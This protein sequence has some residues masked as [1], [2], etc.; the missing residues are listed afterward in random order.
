MNTVNS[1]Y[2]KALVSFQMIYTTNIMIVMIILLS[3]FLH[4]TVLVELSENSPYFFNI[5][6]KTDQDNYIAGAEGLLNSTWPANNPFFYSPY[7]S[8]YLAGTYLVH[9]DHFTPRFFQIF[10]G[11]L[12]VVVTNLPMSH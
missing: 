10:L 7:Y 5:Q 8:Y 9:Q 6:R 3:F 11:I 2:R 12:L 4:L 1:V